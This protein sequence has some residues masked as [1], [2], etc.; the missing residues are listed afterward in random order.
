V[1]L[2]RKGQQPTC[3][4]ASINQEQAD[5]LRLSFLRSV[6]VSKL[7]QFRGSSIETSFEKARIRQAIDQLQRIDVMKFV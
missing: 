3:N 7:I 4:G 5:S 2:G 1:A 6:Y